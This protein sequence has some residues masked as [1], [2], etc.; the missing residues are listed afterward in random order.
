MIMKPRRASREPLPRSPLELAHPLQVRGPE[1]EGAVILAELP[2]AT[3]APVLR[4]LRLLLAFARG[5]AGAAVLQADALERWEAELHQHTADPLWAPAVTI[6]AELGAGE[7]A[8]VRQISHAC[9]AACEW[10]LEQGAWRSAL[11]FAEAAALAWPSNPRP[12]WTAGRM[13]RNYGRM[14]EAELWLRRAA[15]IA[16]WNGDFETQDLALNSLGNLFAQQGCYKQALLI[17]NRALKLAARLSRERRGCVSHDLL[18]VFIALGQHSRAEDMAVS[19]LRL[20]GSSHRKLPRLAYD[21]VLLWME[22]GRFQAALPVLRS[23][24]PLLKRPEERLRV[25]GAL[26]RAAG[27][28]QES[29]TFDSA[30]TLAWDQIRAAPPDAARAIPAV[31]VEVGLGAASLKDW[32]R[33]ETAFSEALRRAEE[34]AQFDTIARAEAGLN[35][36]RRHERIS[37]DQRPVSRPVMQLAEAFV[38]VLQ[39]G[40]GDHDGLDDRTE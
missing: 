30:W 18:L 34:A 13:L 15:R 23:L 38:R 21:V 31:L 39:A 36:A 11:L 29:S 17:L 2:P 35:A 5:P 33:A 12:A 1:A 20:Y 16:V 9:M 40:G 32:N 10:L 22:R 25:V 8:D 28:C 3:A 14:R 7:G 37:I 26:A 4:L 24:M 6:L 27:A 19:A